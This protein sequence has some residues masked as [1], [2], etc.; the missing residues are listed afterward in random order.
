LQE[1]SPATRARV[2][3]A[4]TIGVNDDVIQEDVSR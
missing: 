4:S 2:A 3:F 1:D